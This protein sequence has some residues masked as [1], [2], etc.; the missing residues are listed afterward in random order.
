MLIRLY[1][2]DKMANA[3]GLRRSLD[4]VAIASLRAD[5]PFDPDPPMPPL[6]AR[7]I[8]RQ[9]A[10]GLAPPYL[11]KDEAPPSVDELPT[12]AT[13]EEGEPT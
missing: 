8:E 12:R 3:S 4:P 9:A 10:T 11:T 5:P 7:M 1:P 6:L 13:D 2:Q